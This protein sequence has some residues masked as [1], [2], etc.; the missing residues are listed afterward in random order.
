MQTGLYTET[1]TDN[2]AYIAF[3]CP[4]C[5]NQLVLHFRDAANPP[6]PEEEAEMERLRLEER[7]K[8]LKASTT[9]DKESKDE[10]KEEK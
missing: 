10:V 1:R 7:E 6:T 4:N 5:D 3:A 8:K 9:S 2:K